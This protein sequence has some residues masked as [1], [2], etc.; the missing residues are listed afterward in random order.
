MGFGSATDQEGTKSLALF[1]ELK[2]RSEMSLIAARRSKNI[3]PQLEEGPQQWAT[4]GHSMEW[5]FGW[6]REYIPEAQDVQPGETVS[7]VES[8]TEAGLFMFKIKNEK[9]RRTGKTLTL[10]PGKSPTQIISILETF[11]DWGERTGLFFLT[12]HGYIVG[13]RHRDDGKREIFRI[14]HKESG[15]T[16][17]IGRTEV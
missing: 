2:K 13:E 9:T 12:R 11:N 7:L 15:T 1:Q 14:M 8:P 16:Q 3:V 10:F 4:F 5:G 6:A 17:L